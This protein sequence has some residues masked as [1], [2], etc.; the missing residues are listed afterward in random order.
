LGSAIGR[1]IAAVAI[2]V[3]IVPG[4]NWYVQ[5]APHATHELASIND[6]FAAVAPP[7]Q[8]IA[9]NHAAQYL[10]DTR[11]PLVVT[12]IANNGDFYSDGVR[13]YLAQVTDGPPPGVPGTSWAAR[14]PVACVQWRGLTR[15]CLYKVP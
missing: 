6:T 8:R 12:G 2:A 13:W 5:W 9:G 14:R 3:A 1:T 15:E 7:G 10:L 4:L 11:N